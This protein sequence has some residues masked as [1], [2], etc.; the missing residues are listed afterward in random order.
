MNTANKHGAPAR[1]TTHQQGQ[2]A[3]YV[4]DPPCP[5]AVVLV[6]LG[7]L[8]FLSSGPGPARAGAPGGEALPDT[9]G[10]AL[11]E[12][13]YDSWTA[14][15][16]QVTG[17]SPML[18]P[19]SHATLMV[20]ACA[21]ADLERDR[22]ARHLSRE[23]C[24]HRMA[25]IRADQDSALIFRLD[26]RTFSFPG[27]AGLARLDARTTLMLEDDRGGRWSPLEIRR[28]PA[29]LAARGG[30]LRRLYEYH[31]PWVRGGEHRGPYAYDAAPGRDLT[32][33]EHFVRF[34]RRDVRSRELVLSSRTRWLRLRLR[35]PGYEW[36]STWTFRQPGDREP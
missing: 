36:V 19:A 25:D 20:L 1:A 27:S 21:S 12:W 16:V 33:A 6:L 18:A 3:T 2:A 22:L 35:A 29:V 26:L 34:A 8:M 13:A 9:S 32:I 11:V 5:G 10:M 28:G 4:G 23:E 14:P 7:I 24:E 17:G 15:W 31:P 30:K